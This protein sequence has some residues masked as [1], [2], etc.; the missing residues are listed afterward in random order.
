MLEDQDGSLAGNARDLAKYKLV[1]DQI[2]Q[3][4][5]GNVGKGFDDFV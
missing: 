4:R 3:H 5:D 2:S 1:G